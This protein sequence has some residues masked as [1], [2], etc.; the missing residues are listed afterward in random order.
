MEIYGIIAEVFRRTSIFH[1][2]CI[3]NE[4]TK[5]FFHKKLR[6]FSNLNSLVKRIQECISNMISKLSNNLKL[7]K[8]LT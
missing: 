6:S 3:E 4:Q 2:F 1:I 7:Q 5:H 8:Y